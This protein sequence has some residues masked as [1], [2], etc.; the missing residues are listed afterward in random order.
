[1][2]TPS[3]AKD[4]EGLAKAYANREGAWAEGKTLHVAGTKSLRDVWDDAKIPLGLTS[5]SKRCHNANLTLRAL[6]Q[7]RR[8]VGAVALELGAKTGKETTTYGAP[9]ISFKGGDRYKDILDP[10]AA[11]DFGAKTTILSGM[12]PHAYSSISSDRSSP[13]DD[14]APND[15]Y[16]V[17]STLHAYR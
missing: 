7:V 13:Q 17:G 12:N 9:V 2:L 3:I 15:G 5:Q 11:F 16:M 4:S 1:M 10:I 6:P 8:T 14:G